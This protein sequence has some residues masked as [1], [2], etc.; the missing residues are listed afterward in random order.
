LAI[1]FLLAYFLREK[2]EDRTGEGLAK[3][4]ELWLS[5]FLSDAWSIWIL[6]SHDTATKFASSDMID[7]FLLLPG[8]SILYY[9]EEIGLIMFYFF[10]LSL[11]KISDENILFK[12][13][14]V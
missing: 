10:K 6:S 2:L 4:T 11:E 5:K 1:H 12:F 9:G 14:L 13:F 8:R 3:F 7:G